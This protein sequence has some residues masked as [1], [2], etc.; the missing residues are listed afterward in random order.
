MEE[1]KET[2]TFEIRVTAKHKL[3]KDEMWLV[4]NDFMYRLKGFTTECP[5]ELIGADIRLKPIID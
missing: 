2:Q 4:A 3:T 1:N 5:N